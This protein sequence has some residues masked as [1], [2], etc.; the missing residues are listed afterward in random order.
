MTAA[1]GPHADFIVASYAAAFVIILA[2]IAWVWRDYR[3][4]MRILA[5]LERG[6]ITRRSARAASHHGSHHGA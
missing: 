6:G 5:E 1:L 2:M 3:R 4:Q